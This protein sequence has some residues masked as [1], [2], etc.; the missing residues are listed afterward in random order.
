M[1]KIFKY[2]IA[3][4]SGI[5]LF[6]FINKQTLENLNDGFRLK[7]YNIGKKKYTFKLKEFL[8]IKEATSMVPFNNGFLI[9]TKYGKLIYYNNNSN[10]TYEIINMRNVYGFTDKGSEEGLLSVTVRPKDKSKIYISYTTVINDKNYK[11]LLNID[12][13]VIKDRK[14]IRNKN[15]IQIPFRTNYHHG[16]TIEFGPDDKLYLGTGD[17]GPQKD[18]YNESQNPNTLRG[19]ILRINPETK[20]IEIVALG[21]RNPWKFSFDKDKIYLGDVGYNRV[22]KINLIEDLNKQYNFGWSYYEGSL[23][24]KPG[25]KFEEFDPPIFEYLRNPKEKSL[26]VIGGYFDRNLNIYVFGDYGGSIRA[27]QKNRNKWEE[28]ANDKIE[29]HIYSLGYDGK[30]IYVCTNK[31]IYKLDILTF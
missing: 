24:F 6:I 7:F 16:G 21:L 31:K 8:N 15:I 28:I 2:I 5:L 11:S 18:P 26:S 10:N 4:I 22:E 19:K 27:I 20:E 9:T 23:I 1:Y 25:K 14:F 3:G 12:E 17:G 13:F 29:E 30:N